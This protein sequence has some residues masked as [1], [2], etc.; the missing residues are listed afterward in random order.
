[1]CG[2]SEAGITL[3]L[4]NLASTSAGV[5]SEFR[6]RCS[7]AYVSKSHERDDEKKQKSVHENRIT[8]H[9]ARDSDEEKVVVCGFSVPT[10]RLFTRDESHD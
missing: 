7:K 2:S 3:S 5:E 6:L 4:I 8:I 9:R 1:M 10:V